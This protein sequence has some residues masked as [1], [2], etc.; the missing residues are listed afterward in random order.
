M[1]SRVAI[2]A[3]VLVTG[4]WLLSAALVVVWGANDRMEKADAIVVLGAAQYAGRPSPVLK[5][6]L[7]H[8]IELYHAK[9]A[10]T[11][12]LTGGMG[13]GD[14]TSEAAVSA[15]YVQKRGVPQSAIMLETEGRTTSQ[16]LRAV[17]SMMSD[18][19]I[20]TAIL[21]SDPF[22]MLRLRILAGRMGI[23]AFTSPTRTSPI[24]ANREQEWSYVFSESLK[25]PFALLLERVD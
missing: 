23:G 21:V 25:V 7:D 14:T 4:A 18:R 3:L 11:M 16:S 13:T 8:A 12:I 5:A 20:S 6:R 9:M 19:R 10:P 22:H 17:A 24:A 15:R 2:G 1:W